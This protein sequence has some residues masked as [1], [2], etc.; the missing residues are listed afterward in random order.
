[1]HA[2]GGTMYETN[3]ISA[4]SLRVD[5]RQSVLI[6]STNALLRHSTNP[7]GG[8]KPTRLHLS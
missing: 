2:Q 7:E 6:S 5:T 3:P 4:Q 1:M 8:M